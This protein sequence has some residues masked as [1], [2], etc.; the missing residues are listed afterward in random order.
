LTADENDD[1]AAKACTFAVQIPGAT[2]GI[3]GAAGAD[4]VMPDDME[5]H[6]ELHYAETF[7]SGTGCVANRKQTWQTADFISTG[8][9][10]FITLFAGETCT[11]ECDST[12]YGAGQL[13]LT[14]AADA[15]PATA[16]TL[17]GEQCVPKVVDCPK[18][19][20][21][22]IDFEPQWSMADSAQRTRPA[23]PGAVK[24]PQHFPQ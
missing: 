9:P 21:T 23:P 19:T 10:D 4:I 1:A 16:P 20:S 12:Y 15:A 17:T 5:S 14:C 22:P 13:T 6:G 8:I 7:T 18:S 2:N 24:R 3:P 11:V